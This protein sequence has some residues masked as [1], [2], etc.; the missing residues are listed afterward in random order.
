MAILLSINFS[1]VLSDRSLLLFPSRF[2][3]YMYDVRVTAGNNPRP[4]VY[5]V[6]EYVG[7]LKQCMSGSYARPT[8]QHALTCTG[9]S[10]QHS[11][12]RST[13]LQGEVSNTNDDQVSWASNESMLTAG[14]ED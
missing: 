9:S 11:C 6:G 13:T 14:G 7:G 3:H 5:L 10:P 12:N 2:R 8:Q 1:V 4:I